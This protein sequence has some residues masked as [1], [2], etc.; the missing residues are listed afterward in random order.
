MPI[1]PLESKNNWSVFLKI[2][3]LG[4]LMISA[5]FVNRFFLKKN[6]DIS[7]VL[8]TAQEIKQI[9]SSNLITD[10][11][12]KVEDVAGTVLGEATDTVNKL[13]SDTG[14]YI[15]SIIYDSSIGK[16]VEQVDKLP[17]DQQEKIKEQICK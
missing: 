12:K 13:A 11:I 15:S 7:N 5:I 2:T 3:L 4:G 1:K 14:S 6:K 8:G 16:I 10:S 9:N 17:K